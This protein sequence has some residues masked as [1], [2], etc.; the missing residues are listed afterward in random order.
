VLN[1]ARRHLCGG[2]RRRM[3]S[4][5]RFDDNRSIHNDRIGQQQRSLGSCEADQQKGE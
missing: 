2:W 5:E 4:C 3:R 1:V